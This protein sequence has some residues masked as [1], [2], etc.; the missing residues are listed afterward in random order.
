MS[1][2]QEALLGV[3]WC[4]Y[5]TVLALRVW[6]HRDRTLNAARLRQLQRNGRS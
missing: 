2:Y 5:L 4:T 3:T 1:S 6:P